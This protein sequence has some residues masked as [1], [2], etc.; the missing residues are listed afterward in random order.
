MD[1][2][3]LKLTVCLR[4][5]LSFEEVQFMMKLPISSWITLKEWAFLHRVQ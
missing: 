1:S 3:L 4:S 2:S 5:G